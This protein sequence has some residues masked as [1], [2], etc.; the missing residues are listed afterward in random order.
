[1]RLTLFDVVQREIAFFGF[2]VNDAGM[3]LAE[4]AAHAVLTGQAHGITFQQQAAKSHSFGGGPVDAFAGLEHLAL[5]FQQ[6][7]DGLMSRKTF[8]QGGQGFANLSQPC[9]F[10]GGLPALVFAALTIQM[11]P[12][13]IQPIGLVGAEFLAGLKLFIQMGLEGSLH[14]LDLALWDQAIGHQT[15]G[16][17]LQCRLVTLDVFVHQGICEHRFI[18]FVMA[19]AAV[20]E[21]VQNHVLVEFLPKLG[22]DFGRMNNRFWVVTIDVENR[23]FNHQRDIRRIGRGAAEMRGRGKSDLVI[24]HDMHGAAGL[25][26]DQT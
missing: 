22:R 25:V 8:G 24:N 4:S 3:A 13:A 14:I 16:I 12:A 23:R 2:L 15:F 10:K 1:M 5:A 6:A 17:K 7:F 20:A 11:R 21:D 19:K 18:P 9:R 26:P